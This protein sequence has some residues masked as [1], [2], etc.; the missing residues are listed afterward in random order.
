MSI[1]FKNILF[2]KLS[3]ISLTFLI[4]IVFTISENLKAENI[5]GS[6]TYDTDTNNTQ[7]IFTEDDA[8][9][10][11]TG[12]TTLERSRKLFILTALGFYCFYIIYVIEHKKIGAKL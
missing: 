6:Q 3:K 8:S 7:Y 2:L 12:N 5:T 4:I 9:A 11:V 10:V 1:R